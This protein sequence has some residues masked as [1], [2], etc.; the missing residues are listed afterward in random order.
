MV[1]DSSNNIARTRT[2]L[3]SNL[4]AIQRWRIALCVVSC[5]YMKMSFIRNCGDYGL[6]E[7]AAASLSLFLI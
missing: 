3:G 4:K 1:I 6:L 7:N 2:A 5:R